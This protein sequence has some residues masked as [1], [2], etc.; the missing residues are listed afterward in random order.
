ME[1]KTVLV[2]DDET[3]LAQEIGEYLENAGFGV[4]TADRPS[5]AFNILQKERIDIALV[6]IKLPE[7]DGLGFLGRLREKYPE[8][9]S[10][11]MS[12]HGDMDSVIEALRLGAFDYLR[13]P[14]ST[15]DLQT[16]ISRTSRFLEAKDS[17]RRY[18]QLCADL[19]RELAEDNDMVGASP[20]MREVAAQLERAAAHPDTA[21]L[22]H[23]E[24]GTGKELAARRIHNL[25]AR[26]SG[27]FIAVNCAAIPRD[28]FESEFFGHAKG[29]FTDAR[30]NRAGLFRSA[31]GGTL[32][33]DEVG[34]VPLDSQAKLLR[35][36]EDGSLRPVGADAE[37]KVNVRVL[38]A[39]NRDLSAQVRSGAFRRDLYYRLAV[40]EIPLPP[41]RERPEDIVELVDLFTTRFC[42]RS[43]AA[44]RLLSRGLID[45][46]KSY[47][48]PGN[49]RE[50]KNLVE[51][52]SILGRDPTE[53][54]LCSWLDPEGDYCGRRDTEAAGT[55]PEQELNLDRLE[56]AAIRRALDHAGGVRA[57]AARLLGISRQSLD[58]RLA[59]FSVDARN[60][61][62]EIGQ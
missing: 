22:I 52:I 11:M 7:Y 38:C 21:V 43:G 49:V 20:A 62:P 28:M 60:R 17:T 44:P 42:L 23:G 36:L 51:R 48:F 24:S 50:L 37:V 41:L 4:R 40:I 33:L 54:D 14:F 34:E 8:I 27:R 35:V 10:I 13:K 1:K 31:D 19:N 46:L 18:A 16:A 53:Q 26:A 25:S 47:A 9:E 32:F 59:R 6:D 58:R 12:G 30:D 2:L 56:E 45:R 3:R 29:A 57:A 15:F 61:T 55:P 5:A 39:T